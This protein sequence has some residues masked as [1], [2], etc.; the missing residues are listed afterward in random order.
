VYLAA[1]TRKSHV[2]EATLLL[3]RAGRDLS[4]IFSTRW[5]K[6]QSSIVDPNKEYVIPFQALCGVQG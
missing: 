2:E 1:G 3:E 5:G 4:T 6:R